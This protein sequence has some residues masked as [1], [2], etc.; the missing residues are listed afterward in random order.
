MLTA[1]AA[2]RV[3]NRVQPI[4]LIER[5][6]S[7]TCAAA[8]QWLLEHAAGPR[9]V[10][11]HCFDPHT[12]YDAPAM[13]RERFARE[14]ARWT[15]HGT[16]VVAWPVADYDAEIRETDGQVG[17]LATEFLAASDSAVVLLTADHGEGLGQ[18][19]ELTHGVQ[20]YQEDL[21]VPFVEVGATMPGSPVR[22]WRTDRRLLDVQLAITHSVLGL[23]HLLP[24]AH[25]ALAETFAPEGRQDRTAVRVGDMKLIANRET[26]EEEVYDLAAD[27]GE[28]R[29]LDPADRRWATLRD[30]LPPPR[31][32]RRAGVDAETVRRLRA[33]GYIHDE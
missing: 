17:R 24:G 5:R 9:F 3:A 8:R 32:S 10:W 14:S 12:P 18:H 2:V 16:R 15:T 23:P 27:P 11:V 33:L 13:L 26:G 7:A 21:Q 6:A 4:D 20:L 19:G 1:L 29:P 30:L 25:T 22:S 31:E 28:T